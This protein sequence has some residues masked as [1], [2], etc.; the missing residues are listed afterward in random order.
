MFIEGSREVTVEVLIIIY[1]L[2]YHPSHKLEVVQV[3]RAIVTETEKER[4][5][6]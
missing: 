5:L 6:E 2:S 3:I 1:S 4:V